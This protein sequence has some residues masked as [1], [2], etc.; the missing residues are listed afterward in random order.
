MKEKSFMKE[1]KT[2]DGIAKRNGMKRE[3]WK[4]VIK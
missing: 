2:F 3:K 4:E 1:K